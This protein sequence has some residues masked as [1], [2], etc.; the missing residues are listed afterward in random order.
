MKSSILVFSSLLLCS[1]IAVEI[2]SLSFCLADLSQQC[3]IQIVCVTTPC[4]QP[5]PQSCISFVFEQLRPVPIDP[6][7]VFPIETLPPAPVPP[8]PL[9]STPT[10]SPTDECDDPANIAEGSFVANNLPDCCTIAGRGCRQLGESC[11]T[12]AVLIS[13]P[14]PC[15]PGLSCVITDPGNLALDVPNSGT[16]QSV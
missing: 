16:C 6:P 2:C 14:V 7:I 10:P 3:R 13:R 12:T 4:P 11:S 1:A 9:S 8:T 5:P 15:E